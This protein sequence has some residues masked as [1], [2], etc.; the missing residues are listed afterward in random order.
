MEPESSDW[1]KI[2]TSDLITIYE[3]F[4]GRVENEDGTRT[5][6]LNRTHWRKCLAIMREIDEELNERRP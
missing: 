3:A 2:S 1:S 4:H 6:S 5:I